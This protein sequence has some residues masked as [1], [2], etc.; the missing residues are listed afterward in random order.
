MIARARVET[1]RKRVAG[2]VNGL[3]TGRVGEYRYSVTGEPNL[4]ASCYAL[5]TL[6]YVN[7]LPEDPELRSAW[8]DYIL[9]FQDPATGQ[10]LGPELRRPLPA[11]A[12]HDFE[13]LAMHLAVTV[14]PCLDILGVKPRYPLR[15]AHRFLDAQTLALWLAQRDWTDAWLE[16]NNLLFVLQLL[17]YLRDDEG[18]PAAAARVDE[19]FAWLDANID[20]A[21]GLWGTNGYCS[22]FVAMCGGYHQLLAYYSE[23][24]ALTSPERLIDVTL[25]LQHT[26]GGFNP[27]G[28]GGACEDVDAVD[29]LVNLYKRHDHKRPLIR[30]SLR[31]AMRS[32]LK[33]QMPDGGFVYR[34]D[35]PFMH[36][37][38]ELTKTPP[39]KS[40][41]FA[42]WFRLHTIALISQVMDS[43]SSETSGWRF[44]PRMSMGWHD[45]S[46]H[47]PI[48][49]ALARMFGELIFS[50]R[51]F[52]VSH[53][54]GDL[55]LAIRR[56]IPY[57][58]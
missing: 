57:R 17:I 16:G 13:H 30:M 4:Y 39:N 11:G 25:E 7:E 22:N 38:M 31:A 33:K 1:L 26:D 44:N 24:R 14:L 48:E 45:Q 5:M 43:E 18:Q 49:S 10:F 50:P 3:N 28:G 21:T 6:H 2:F 55:R 40:N 29:I 46:V 42:T 36:M 54:D 41:L 58:H 15:F 34:L 56:L 47:V 12:K 23:G 9:S 8:A 20:P 32:I 51:R 19:F 35:E 27:N 52:F 53:I 37:G